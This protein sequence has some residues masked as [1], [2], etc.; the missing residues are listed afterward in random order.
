MNSEGKA[1][2][3]E[4]FLPL[5]FIYSLLYLDLVWSSLVPGVKPREESEDISVNFTKPPIF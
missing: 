1:F 4:L 2:R 3:E 5:I